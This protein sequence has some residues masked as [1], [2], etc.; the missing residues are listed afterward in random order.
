[1]GIYL[2]ALNETGA[3]QIIGTPF[4]RK[5]E[6]GVA[7]IDRLHKELSTDGYPLAEFMSF[8]NFLTPKWLDNL[9]PIFDLE[10][11]VQ[12]LNKKGWGRLSRPTTHLDTIIS[13]KRKSLP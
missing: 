4:F 11:S 12:V 7:W 13:L 3:I 6:F 5:K 1:M 10:W 2:Q 9:C 8:E